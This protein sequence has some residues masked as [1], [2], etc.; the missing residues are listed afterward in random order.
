MNNVVR[1]YPQLTINDYAI[2]RGQADA[3]ACKMYLDFLKD[4]QA[5]S[6]INTGAPDTKPPIRFNPDTLKE[7]ILIE[8]IETFK[9]FEQRLIDGKYFNEKKKWIKTKPDLVTFIMILQKN[10]YFIKKRNGK[11]LDF[12]YYRK[13]FEARYDIIIS[14]ESQPNRRN[15]YVLTGSFTFISQAN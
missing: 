10:G 14:K 4:I 15:K 7:I 1:G 13:F 5:S 3:F 6:K 2:A 8:H 11:T 9:D 12:T